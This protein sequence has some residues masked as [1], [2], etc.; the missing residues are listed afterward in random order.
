[1]R[2][3]AGLAAV[4]FLIG[5][6]A[7]ILWWPAVPS[8]G[9]AGCAGAAVLA[10][11]ASATAAAI[12]D[13]STACLSVIVGCLL[14]GLALGTAAAGRVYEPPLLEWYASHETPATVSLEGVLREDGAATAYGAS[15]V[16]DVDRI[17]PQATA[18]GVRLSV[19]GSLAAGSIAEW[20]RGRRVRVPALLRRPSEH[21]NPGGF[22]Q[23]RALARRGICLVG[24]VKSAAL[25]EILAK[26]SLV[27]EAAS[28]ARLWARR[29][30]GSAIAPASPRSAAVATAILIGDRTQLEAEDER[31][32]QEAGTYHV[33]AISGGNIAMATALLL[34]AGRICFLRA[35]TS[36]ALAIV[37]L[38]FYVQ[39]AGSAP[40]VMRAVTAAV[41]FLA[42]RVVDHRGPPLN[43]L[44]VAS[45]VTVAAD[46]EAILDA[47]FML[48]FGATL[49]IL[50][51][52]P[53]LIR[54]QPAPRRGARRIAVMV[55]RALLAILVATICAELV[56]AP[57]SASFFGRV[58]V[59]GLLLNFA[60]IP[61]MSV[62]Q[63]AG[64][65][66]LAGPALAPAVSMACGRI[67]HL[68]ASGLVDSARLVEIVPWLSMAVAPPAWQ[69]LVVYYVALLGILSARLRRWALAAVAAT[70]A[71][72]LAGPFE[73]SKGSVASSRYPLR[74][75]SLDV[76]Q[77]DATVITVGRDHAV[78][79]DAGGVAAFST[80]ADDQA[81]TNFDV[82]ERVV[83]PALRAMGIAALDALVVTHGDPD[84]I[85][86]APAILHLLNVKSVWEG[87]PVPP[88]PGLQTLRRLAAASRVS[89]RTVQAGD[90][91]QFDAVEIRVWHPPL[92]EW[93]R[94]RIR[95]EDSI[96]LEVRLGSVSI[97]LTGDIGREGERAILS[98]IEPGRLT[99]LKAGHH[100]SATS[101]APELLAALAPAAVIFSAGRDNRFGHPHPT[102]VERFEARGT[103]IFRTD[104]DGAV[105]VETDGTT[106]QMRGWTGKAAA[107]THTT[108]AHAGTTPRRH[109]GT[110]E[111]VCCA[112]PH[113]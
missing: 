33:I 106:V 2:V 35:S 113:R 25:V 73:L 63:L 43:A 85:L 91:E 48:S 97:L 92:P 70:G 60:A 10:L 30:L 11:L 107:F 87:V 28:Q 84:H 57:V 5:A 53:L 54:R 65:A 105:F 26:G 108:I 66:V 41:V 88:H 103:A 44:G 77:G 14:S 109:D 78:L 94:Q 13:C 4:P 89:W 101:S 17:G 61:L 15:I 20:R 75:V 81:S 9:A 3:P 58:T 83:V 67:A 86:G 56:L 18:G 1:M 49:G 37:A 96:V 55:G 32:L 24:S 69:E 40:S 39:I 111:Y 59:A 36:A 6:A 99:V 31:R 27:E 74:V 72:M 64:A 8:I 112:S 80:P 12:D 62:V 22:E 23:G 52:A 21:R 19:V 7:A 16:V 90:R 42:G 38:L 82:G 34:L 50:L 46:P 68:A 95:N 102:V 110:T 104:R 45:V 98:R 47:G 100:G 93:E 76:G 71:V 51:G 79:V 29:K